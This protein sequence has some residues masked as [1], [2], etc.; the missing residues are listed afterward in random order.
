ME[1]EGKN[2][3]VTGAG[4]FIGSQLVAHLKKLGANILPFVDNNGKPI[5]MADWQKIE[6]FRERISGTDLIY[7]LAAVTS[8]P[9]SVKDPRETYRINLLGTL[10]ILELGRLL[11]VKK[12]IFISS[13]VYGQ[14]QY[15]P[16]D[17]KH[18][19]KPTNPYASSKLLGEELCRAYYQDYGLECC[20]L[21]LFNV[22]GEGQ[23]EGFLIP[24][25]LK[26]LESGRVEL[27]DPEPRR[28]FL[29]IRDVVKAF[30][31][32]GEYKGEGFD[33]F[34]IGSGAS[35]SVAE[36]VGEV[37]SIWGDVT[38]Y[39]QNQRRKN[40]VMNI[41]AD[42]SKAKEKLGWEPSVGIKEGL[43]GYIDWY[44]KTHL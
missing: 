4:G 17:E 15:L 2:I 44:K 24:T 39:Y 22:Y 13:Y 28:D 33:T 36:I 11:R 14:P 3:L 40:E 5:D 18:P 35:Y 32:A 20:I 38:V 19:I 42:R 10:N 7:H 21:R 25:I 6:E 41:V 27:M 34:N 1:L 37:V 23:N 8:A 16:V 9:K 31:K 12:F 43:R 26:Q 29:H 30:I